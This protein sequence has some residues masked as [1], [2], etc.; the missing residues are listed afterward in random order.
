[1]KKFK[2]EDCDTYKTCNG[3]EA[4]DCYNRSN[5]TLWQCKGCMCSMC[6][7]SKCPL[8]QTK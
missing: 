7:K 3:E 8:R 4:E 2:V 6:G 5:P 1:M